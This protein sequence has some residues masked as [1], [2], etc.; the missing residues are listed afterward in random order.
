MSSSVSAK[1]AAKANTDGW[2]VIAAIAIIF[3]I[4]LA[5]I[6]VALIK[7]S[8][9]A[10]VIQRCNPG[11][12]KFSTISGIKTC[13]ASGDPVGVQVNLGAE[14]CTSR[15]FCQK[16]NFKCAI[17]LDQTVLCN[18]VCGTGNDACRCV[19]NPFAPPE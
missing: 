19:R 9:S 5:W 14:F 2:V 12:C 13:P 3:A 15:D 1:D 7:D 17:Q 6:I 18:G 16:E 8:N 10:I 11:L 4:V